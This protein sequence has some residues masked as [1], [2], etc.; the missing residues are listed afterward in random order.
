MI[1]ALIMVAGG[2]LGVYFLGGV[3]VAI[4]TSTAVAVLGWFLLI[5]LIRMEGL[6][7]LTW[8]AKPLLIWIAIFGSFYLLGESL[9]SLAQ[10]LLFCS[11]FMLILSRMLWID[12]KALLGARSS[13][14]P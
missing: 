6:N 3:G 7:P 9:P 8:I 10:I 5:Q 14:I 11:S 13:V 4:A 12:F 2:L 1:A